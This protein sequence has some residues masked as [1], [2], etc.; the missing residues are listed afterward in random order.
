M[1]LESHPPQGDPSL[2]QSRAA[3]GGMRCGA[4]AD[5]L[6]RLDLGDWSGACPPEDRERA[7][8]ALE[9]GKI[10]FL[11]H[12]AF[13]LRAEERRFLDPRVSDG[14]AKNISFDPRTG[15]LGGTS[16]AGG[17]RAALA[18]LLHRFGTAAEALLG[19]LFPG[20]A[21][22]LERGRASLRPVSID[23]RRTSCR[24]DDTRLH[25]DAFPSQPVQG[26]RILRVFANVNAA[27]AAR[28]WRVGG[29]FADY[30]GRFLPRQRL[31]PVPGA[32][33]AF[34]CLGVTK[35][36]RTA[37]DWLMLSLHDSAKADAAYQYEGAVAELRFP[38]GSSWIVYTDLVPHAAIA[39]QHALEQTFYLPVAAMRDP[40]MS[41]LRILEGLTR[42]RLAG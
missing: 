10:V 36:R 30:A 22:Q 35:G 19:G 31:Y 32:T 40:E 41:P 34:A 26:R 8:A 25:V 18:A 39:G 28:V 5:P 27:G 24:K 1:V 14:K 20:Y 7:L 15:A 9:A 2:G 12:L 16:L 13:E 42:R 11:P 23:R 29:P 6:E 17:E 21:A 37:Y 3:V 33:A 38:P 4:G